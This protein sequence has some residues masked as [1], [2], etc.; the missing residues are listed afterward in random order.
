MGK[1]REIEGKFPKKLKKFL[2]SCG[3]IISVLH[4]LF[5]GDRIV[6]KTFELIKMV[7][8]VAWRVVFF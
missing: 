2:E 4:Y 1:D 3:F 5:L 6:R 7:D 8:R